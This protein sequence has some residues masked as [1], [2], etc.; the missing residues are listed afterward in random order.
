[1]NSGVKLFIS[2]FSKNE[3]YSRL[4]PKKI[5]FVKKEWRVVGKNI[6]LKF[7]IIIVSFSSP[8]SAWQMRKNCWAWVSKLKRRFSILYGNKGFGFD[9]QII[10]IH[11]RNADDVFLICRTYLLIVVARNKLSHKK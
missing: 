4:I 1:M 9:S 7:A 2:L 10:I 5:L 3:R 11:Q 8:I 6:V